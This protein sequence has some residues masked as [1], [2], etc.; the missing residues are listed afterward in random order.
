[1][2]LLNPSVLY[3]YMHFH[4][5]QNF[6]LMKED[7]LKRE[8][9]SHFLVHINV[10]KLDLENINDFNTLNNFMLKSTFI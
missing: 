3:M 1:M 5:W 10:Y 6:N 7:P 8:K 9:L 2:L 4:E